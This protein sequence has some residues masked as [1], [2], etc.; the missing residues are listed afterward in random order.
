MSNVS[1]LP[2]DIVGKLVALVKKYDESQQFT[3]NLLIGIRERIQSLE[4]GEGVDNSYSTQ[5]LNLSS[6]AT[7]TSIPQSLYSV[8]SN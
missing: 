3:C 4:K 1:H 5:T 2:S 7:P 8:M 6:W